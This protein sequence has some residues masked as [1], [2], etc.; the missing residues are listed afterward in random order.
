M[1]KKQALSTDSGIVNVPKL[2]NSPS[3]VDRLIVD[4]LREYNKSWILVSRMENLALT[5]IFDKIQVSFKVW[6][7]KINN[8]KA[9]RKCELENSQIRDKIKCQTENSDNDIGKSFWSFEFNFG[10]F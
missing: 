8:V 4:S 7:N 6:L 5:I 1:N 10:Y 2:T 9:I 3:R